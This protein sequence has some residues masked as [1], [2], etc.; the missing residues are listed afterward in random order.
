MTK[1]FLQVLKIS[2]VLLLFTITV[3]TGAIIWPMPELPL[4]EEHNSTL[5]Q[6]INIIDTKTGKILVNRDVYIENN[7]II[8]IDS[9]GVK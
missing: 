9:S 2:I 7:K 8:S 1:I 4:A 3:I 5:I 6:S